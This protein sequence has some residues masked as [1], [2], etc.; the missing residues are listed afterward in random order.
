MSA[1]F[2]GVGYHCNAERFAARCGECLHCAW[3]ALRGATRASIHL[4]RAGE[5]RYVGQSMKRF[6][7]NAL[8]VT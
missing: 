6:Q 5:S 7:C 4:S 3:R 2:R 1:A 8:R